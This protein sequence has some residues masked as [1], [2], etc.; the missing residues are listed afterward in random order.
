MF[1][2]G[3]IVIPNFFIRYRSHDKNFDLLYKAKKVKF[4]LLIMT[5]VSYKLVESLKNLSGWL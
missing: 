4:F 1:W 5:H 2:H 3:G